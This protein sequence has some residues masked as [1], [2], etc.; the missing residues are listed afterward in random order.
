MHNTM[1]N[2]FNKELDKAF[3][4]YSYDDEVLSHMADWYIDCGECEPNIEDA[5]DSMAEDLLHNDSL[6]CAE[7]YKIV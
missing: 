5:L 2:N 3:E 4:R 1:I 6:P 7:R